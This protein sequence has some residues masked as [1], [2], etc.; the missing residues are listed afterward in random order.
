METSIESFHLTIILCI[1]MGFGV[2][3]H[4]GDPFQNSNYQVSLFIIEIPLI[5]GYGILMHFRRHLDLLLLL[6]AYVHVGGR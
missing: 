1:L 4:C 5:H 2:H 6:C 3:N